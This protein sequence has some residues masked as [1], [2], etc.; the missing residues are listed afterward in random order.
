MGAKKDSMKKV[1]VGTDNKNDCLVECSPGKKCVI[2]LHSKT[3]ILFEEHITSFVKKI[4]AGQ[5]IKK[6]HI[7]IEE[8]GA[9]DYVIKSRIEAALEKVL[10]IPITKDPVIRK[11]TSKS[12]ARRT[13]LYVPGNN[14]RMIT[15]AGIYGSDCIIFDL[16][17]SVPVHQKDAARYLVKNALRDLDFGDSELWVRINKNDMERDLFQVLQGSPHGICIPKV[18]TRDDIVAVEQ[19]VE[20]LSGQV[21]LM[22]IIESAQGIINAPQIAMASK[23]IVALAF[24][25]EDLTRDLGGERSWETLLYPRGVLVHAAK[26]FGIQALD[27]IY[28]DTRDEQ[29]LREETK[30]IKAMGF[31]GKGV[32]HP[33]QIPLIYDCFTPSSEEI[34]KARAI[35]KAL[36]EAKKKGMGAASLDG[37]M[38]DEPV[39]KKAKKI[40]RLAK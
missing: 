4:L 32:I 28:P 40:L 8:N 25:A 11:S 19:I 27:T 34:M 12:R 21:K 30:K 38:I 14:P 35:V 20:E 39:E 22:P 9:L 15:P 29:G 5:G 31:D 33:D 7:T 37:K 26:A 18:E 1:Q 36:R 6:I 3:G 17:D 13:R 24:G 10:G 16:E 2:H 23:H